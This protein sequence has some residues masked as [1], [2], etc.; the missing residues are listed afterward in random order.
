[1]GSSGA[2]DSAAAAGS[3][4]EDDESEEASAVAARRGMTVE[5]RIVGDECLL[6]TS[7]LF[8]KC[9][10]IQDVDFDQSR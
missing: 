2:A 9:T 8:F 7:I 4:E 1:M 5:K 3:E 10:I 6:V